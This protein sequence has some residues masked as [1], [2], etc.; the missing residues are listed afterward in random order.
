MNIEVTC[1]DKIVRKSSNIRD[2]GLKVFKKVRKGKFIPRF[3]N[4]IRWTI[5][6]KNRELALRKF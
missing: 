6:V 1:G 3:R 4:R 5:D 2:K